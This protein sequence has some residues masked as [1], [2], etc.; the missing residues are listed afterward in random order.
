MPDVLPHT[1][2]HCRSDE[3]DTAVYQYQPVLLQSDKITTIIKAAGISV[4]PYWPGL[5]AKLFEKR[6]I[7]D[8]ISNVGAGA[9]SL[10]FLLNVRQSYHVA[11]VSGVE[12]GKDQWC[13]SSLCHFVVLYNDNIH[14]QDCPGCTSG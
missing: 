13:E 8:L 1:A 3:D 5:F 10:S 2:A 9:L 6:S 7:G 14:V 11:C 4:E 12:S